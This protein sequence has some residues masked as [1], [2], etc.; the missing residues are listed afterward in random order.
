Y[1]DYGQVIVKTS[2]GNSSYH[3]FQTHLDRRLARGFQLSA[4]YTWSKMIDSTSDG[5][6]N[7]NVQE[8]AGGNLTSVPVMYGGM[9]LDRAV[10]DFDR[11]HRLTIAYVWVVPAPRSNWLKHSLG[12]LQPAGITTFQS[13]TPYSVA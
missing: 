11:P 10:S 3:S 4:S 2:E 6:G 9:K 8:P 13:G 7:T 5:L 1:P 12:G